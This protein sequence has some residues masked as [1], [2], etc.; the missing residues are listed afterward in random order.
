MAAAMHHTV[1]EVERVTLAEG[2]DCDWALGAELYLPRNPAQ[3]IRLQAQVGDD[4]RWL[5]ADEAGSLCKATNILGALQLPGV[6]YHSRP[7][8]SRATSGWS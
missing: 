7:S 3:A 6:R 2:I 4:A 1:D 5:D 8:R